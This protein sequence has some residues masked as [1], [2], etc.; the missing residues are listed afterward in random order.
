MAR[1]SPKRP[2]R[3]ARSSVRLVILGAL[4]LAAFLMTAAPSSGE[5]DMTI[6][7]RV[8]NGTSG[9]EA[10]AGSEVTLHLIGSGGEVATAT[11]VTAEGGRFVFPD[12]EQ[13]E[14][15]A[16][17]VAARHQEVLYSSRLDP[18]KLGEPVEIII[19]E[20]GSNLDA[21]RIGAQVQ[22]I[23]GVG[24]DGTLSVF[25]VVSLVNEEDRTF[26][27]DL[28]RPA[29]MSF[30]R[31]GLPSEATGLEVASDLAGGSI[32][33]VGSGFAL[34]APVTPGSHNVTY[35][36][37]VPYE[38]GRHE[39]TRSFPMGAETFRLLLA[40]S[41]GDLKDLGSLSAADPVQV[42]GKSYKVWE[43]NELAAASLVS[44]E[45]AGLPQESPLRRLGDALV[46][47]PYLKI[48]I[49]G[50]V[51]LVLVG[52]LMYVLV[53]RKPV[54]P[55]AVAVGT[56]NATPSDESDDLAPERRSLVEEIAMLDDLAQRGEITQEDFRWQRQ[57]LKDRL[58]LITLRWRQD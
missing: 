18:S 38:G 22:L 3:P 29:S 26:V 11:A 54:G 42:E 44:V 10:A 17:A 33:S 30:L 31:F 2:E 15:Y 13:N 52:L 36:Y 21:L 19:Y 14:D 47:G 34:T 56:G 12:V 43:E 25:E 37:G 24:S 9:V 53:L 50:V 6:V 27:P 16:Y 7:G 32:I 57:E 41:L 8:I 45:I 51:G 39:L 49:P 40:E 48:G 20:A 28:E 5:G 23:S 46:D 1:H 4:G 55:R 35:A 58:R